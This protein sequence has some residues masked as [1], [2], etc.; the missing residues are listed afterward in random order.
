VMLPRFG[1]G[2]PT[3]W[4]GRNKTFFFF[5][6]EVRRIIRGATD[7]SST[8]PT[9][10][11]R[12]GDF[13]SGLGGLLYLQSNGTSGTTVTANPLFVTDTNGN[14]VQ[15]RSGMLF[16]PTDGRAYVGNIIPASDISPLAL[17]LLT[18]YPL[19]NSGV[20]TFTF[21]PLNINNTRQESIRI[22]HNF[23]DNQ[24]LFGRYTHDLSET[25]ESGGL[26]NNVLLPDISTTQTRVPGHVLAISLTSILSPT[27]VNE[28]TYNFSGNLIGSQ[29]VGRGRRTDYAGSSLIPEF[30]PE[31]NNNAIP[32]LNF[33]GNGTI[34]RL[35]GLQGFNIKY[36]NHV[37]R[38]VFTWTR[39]THTFKFGGEISY[40]SKDENANNITGGSFTFNALATRGTSGTVALT[41]TGSSLADYLVGRPSQYQEDEFDVTVNLR[42]GRREFF[43]QDT[44]RIRP[45]LT[46]DYGVRYQYFVPVK[47]KNNVLTG[48]DP[49]LYSRAAVPTC[50]TAACTALVRGTGNE[51]NGIA[52]AGSTSRF[53]EA[54]SP[55]DKNNFSPRVGLAW[56]PFKSGKTIVR[57]GYGFYYDQTL[58]G[59]FETSSFVNPPYNNR[60][61]FTG[62]GVTLA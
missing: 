58:V 31:N 55:S 19:P 5:S 17:S 15:A 49:A 32:E 20:N 41:Q 52:V 25:V 29:L 53:G 39:G 6:E 18:G 51:L 14:V 1:E 10:A 40:E 33:S 42:F 9:A 35:A 11:Q 62:T 54:V 28:A 23:N 27:M 37:A 13:S 38:D 56:D 48:F 16:R 30:Y 21:T 36:T 57:L 50:T 24:R 12:A 2:G 22:D 61:T 26:F 4:S 44:W 34:A 8:V 7:A 43:V 45:N 46:V 59:I 47:D 3:H 60:A